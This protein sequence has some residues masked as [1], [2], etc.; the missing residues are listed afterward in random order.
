MLDLSHAKDG[1]VEVV[2]PEDY[3]YFRGHF[4]GTPMLPG[5]VQLSEI[6]VPLVRQLDPN[7]GPLRGLR[8]VRFR[9]PILPGETLTAVVRREAEGYF[10]ELRVGE[11]N[12]ASGTMVFGP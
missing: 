2:I 7:V 3:V 8:R 5:V 9:R 12:A 4:D 6:L 1:H 11:A 10:F